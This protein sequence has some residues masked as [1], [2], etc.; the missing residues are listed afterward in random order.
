MASR[1]WYQEARA[2]CC[3][4]V[5]VWFPTFVCIRT[6]SSWNRAQSKRIPLRFALVHTPVGAS[7]G[8]T[9]ADNGRHE[10]ANRCQCKEKRPGPPTTALTNCR[11]LRHTPPC[12]AHASAPHTP[13]T[14]QRILLPCPL[15]FGAA[16]Q[17]HS[18][19]DLLTF[20]LFCPAASVTPF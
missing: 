11:R 16:A 5:S 14:R 3:C 1:V 2:V 17:L 13:H 15:L 12:T 7:Q 10:G 6:V 9:N 8:R 4:F 18:A 20:R 19:P